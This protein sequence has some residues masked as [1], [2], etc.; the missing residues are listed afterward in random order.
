MSGEIE[1]PAHFDDVVASVA[2]GREAEPLLVKQV[3]ANE[4]FVEAG[5]KTADILLRMAGIMSVM[6]DESI[7]DRQAGLNLRFGRKR[8]SISGHANNTFVSDYSVLSDVKKARVELW[9][10]DRIERY[11]FP[12]WYLVKAMEPKAAFEKL[13]RVYNERKTLEGKEAILNF[14]SEFLAL[15]SRVYSWMERIKEEQEERNQEIVRQ[16]GIQ[17]A[18]IAGGMGQIECIEQK[19]KVLVP[20]P[21]EERIKQLEGR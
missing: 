4:N 5:V 18:I 21:L 16:Q 15:P 20:D 14:Y 8:L 11:D 9:Y 1:V 7:A 10:Y 13:E 12:R 17:A 19:F 3:S 2:A 6:L